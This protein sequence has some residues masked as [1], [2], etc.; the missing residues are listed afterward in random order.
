MTASHSDDPLAALPQRV[1]GNMVFPPGTK[2]WK[3]SM[4]ANLMPPGYKLRYDADFKAW[5]WLRSD[6]M[7]SEMWDVSEAC[8][9]DAIDDYMCNG[10]FL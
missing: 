7:E 1:G 6:G 5:Y 8:V 2:P 10:G 4:P 3:K 9:A